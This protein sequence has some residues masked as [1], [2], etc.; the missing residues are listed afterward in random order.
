ML[1][2][3]MDQRS[4]QM[5]MAKD[6]VHAMQ[7]RF[8]P[9]V[10]VINKGG[11]T[12]KGTPWHRE[13]FT[14]TGCNKVLVGEKFTSRDEKPY[15]ADCFAQQFAKK[16]IRCTQ[17][18]TGRYLC[19]APAILLIF[20]RNAAYAYAI[21]TRTPSTTYTSAE[22]QIYKLKIE[23]SDPGAKSKIQDADQPC[24]TYRQFS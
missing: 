21:I 20:V 13:C 14:C 19:F 15:C 8:V 16:C 17:P 22:A 1:L 24:L 6:Y 3:C 4:R 12:Y 11:I 5:T 7:C 2:D 10:Q 9:V 23:K 18:I